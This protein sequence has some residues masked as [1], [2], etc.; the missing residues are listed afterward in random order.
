MSLDNIKRV[1]EESA[2]Y[3]RAADCDVRA[4]ECWEAI[5]QLEGIAAPSKFINLDKGARAIAKELD[6]K[7]DELGLC[8]PMYDAAKACAKAWGLKYV[9]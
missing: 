9:D 3:F 2:E 8:L 4:H 5:T 7:Y 6:P 1:L